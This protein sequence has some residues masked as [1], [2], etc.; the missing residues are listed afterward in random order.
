M[1]PPT[2]NLS[3]Y[4]SLPF[5]R[6]KCSYCDLNA[7]AGLDA[8]KPGYVAALVEEIRNIGAGTV[9]PIHSVYFGGGT[10]SAIPADLLTI[11]FEALR[12]SFNLVDG[13][14]ISFEGNPDDLDDG[15]LTALRALGVNRL[16]VGV[17]SAQPNE[18]ALFQRTHSF[19]GAQSAI[20]LARRA[21]FDNI[22]LD[23]IYG[24][25]GQTL[26]KWQETVAACQAM[27][28]EHLSI[29]ALSIDFNT[30]LRNWIER[31]LLSEPDDDLAADMY[32][33]TSDTLA[34]DGYSQYEI[35]SWAR[36]PGGGYELPKLACRHNLQ[37]WLSGP[38]LGLGA[39]AHGY[40]RGYRYAN[41]GS[42]TAYIN[43]LHSG[44]P[45][46]Y[47][48]S[49]AVQRQ[50]KVDDRTAMSE[51]M[52]TGLRLT[53][54]GVDIEWFKSRFGA[55]PRSVFEKELERLKRRGL[56]VEQDNRLLLTR[57]ARLVSNWVFEEFV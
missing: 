54:T 56:V 5:C 1:R 7:Y 44:R 31:G 40:H 57:G 12:S 53:E 28:P 21:G 37:Y 9:E 47:P 4:I 30:P 11:L 46:G 14:E 24:I 15:Y 41:I 52:L 20:R 45:A 55:D 35:S 10:P 49:A 39:G 2:D 3:L 48:C 29:Y 16:S 18:L 13:V 8:H 43:R 36:G 33:W 17:Q 26:A 27:S 50:L 25:P 19:Q 6:Q 42:P 22:S 34:N 23:L 38:Y 51:S 32:A